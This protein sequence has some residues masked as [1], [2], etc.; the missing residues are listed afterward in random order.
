M[1]SGRNHHVHN[2]LPLCPNCHLTDQHDPTVAIEPARLRMFRY[3]RDPAILLPQFQPLFIR[4][5]FLKHIEPNE[6]SVDAIHA[7]VDELIAFVGSF[8]MGVFYAAR[9][10]ELLG[11]R[12]GPTL[13][14]S[15]MESG[16]EAEQRQRNRNRSYR[17]R[18]IACRE[19]V[20]HLI[21]EQLR[22]QEWAAGSEGHSGR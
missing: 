11:A 20:A 17:D 5:S 3:Y 21:V 6:E 10:T 7:D 19:N 14:F 1:A 15:G 12:T 13:W 8:K 18:L 9:L 22:F 16:S 2:L 4:M